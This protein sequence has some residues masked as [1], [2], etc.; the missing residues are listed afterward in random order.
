MGPATFVVLVL[1]FYGPVAI[2]AASWM[3]HVGG[4]EG[5]WQ[6]TIGDEPLIGIGLGIAVGAPIVVAT[7]WFTPRFPPLA[8]LADELGAMTGPVSWPVAITVAAAS[9]IAEELLF[10]GVVQVHLGMPLGVVL[11]AAAHVPL[12]RGLWLWP[13]FALGAGALFGG[14][15]AIT[16]AVLAPVVAHFVINALN[17]HWLG[18]RVAEAR[19]L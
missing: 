8:R 7:Q 15:Y 13:I 18:R 2:G 16:D 4:T 9:A 19:A 1:L 17:L 3:V 5:L 10:R 14:L 12:D 11:F 6:H